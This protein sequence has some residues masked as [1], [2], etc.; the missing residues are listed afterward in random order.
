MITHDP[1]TW[2][3]GDRLWM[4]CHAVALT[5]G[6]NVKDSVPDRL[7]N[8]GDISDGLAEFGAACHDG[9]SVTT[10][11]DKETGWHW[12]YQKWSNIMAGKSCVYDPNSSWI[13]IAKHWAGN[14]SAWADNVTSILGVDPTSTPAQY[15]A[16]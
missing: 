1:T 6:A 4:I 14:W 13:E 3:S 9:S 10:F 16:S 15:M 11:P 8:P 12:L 7:N 5:E 2:P